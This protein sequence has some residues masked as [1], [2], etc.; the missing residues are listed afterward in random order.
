VSNVAGKAAVEGCYFTMRKP[1]LRR[2]APQVSFVLDPHG[3]AALAAD[4][5]WARNVR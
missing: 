2:F 1:A 3:N 4:R 5:G